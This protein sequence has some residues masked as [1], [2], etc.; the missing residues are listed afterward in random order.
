MKNQKLVPE[1]KNLLY[2]CKHVEEIVAILDIYPSFQK[3]K[4]TASY[5]YI[6][7][8]DWIQ[9]TNIHS[10]DIIVIDEQLESDG[11]IFHYHFASCPYNCV[12]IRIR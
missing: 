1:I 10:R 2:K 9:M 7:Y 5:Y 11:Y 4:Q 3:Y 12:G 6:P 8:D